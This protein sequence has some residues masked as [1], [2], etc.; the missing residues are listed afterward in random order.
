[1]EELDRLQRFILDKY[2]QWL[3]SK[4]E[5]ETKLI[6]LI[7]TPSPL[8]N[9]QEMIE[10]MLFYKH[11]LTADKQTNYINKL[12][13]AILKVKKTINPSKMHKKL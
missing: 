9:Y 12:L 7:N 1:M 6:R 5:P 11:E 8:H 2:V 13:T 4:S 3:N 10:D